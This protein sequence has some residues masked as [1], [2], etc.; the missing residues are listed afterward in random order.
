MKIS[1]S[2]VLLYNSLISVAGIA[3]NIQKMK[4][5]RHLEINDVKK[6]INY[7][8]SSLFNRYKNEIEPIAKVKQ[9]KDEFSFA[10]NN[11]KFIQWGATQ[12][13]DTIEPP[14]TDNI[15][16]Y[17]V[18]INAVVDPIIQFFEYRD[19]IKQF[20]PDF[21][22]FNLTP[23]EVS[24]RLEIIA[25]EK[26][27]RE[28][29]IVDQ[30]EK[31][32]NVVIA[33][34][35]IDEDDLDDF[36]VKDTAYVDSY[37]VTEINEPKTLMDICEDTQFCTKNRSTAEEHVAG[38][39]MFFIRGNKDYYLYAPHKDIISDS[40]NDESQPMSEES[41]KMI[42]WYLLNG[43]LQNKE[44]FN[45]STLS[46]LMQDGYM[47]ELLEKEENFAEE[48]HPQ[49]KSALLLYSQKLIPEHSTKI[50]NS[51]YWNIDPNSK[52]DLMIKIFNIFQQLQKNSEGQDALS[53]MYIQE[54]ERFNNKTVFNYYA[55]QIRLNLKDL[56]DN[57]IPELQQ[58]QLL[59]PGLG[60]DLNYISKKSFENQFNKFFNDYEINALYSG[61]VF[62]NTKAWQNALRQGLSPSEYLESF[63]IEEN[64]IDIDKYIFQQTT[65][66]FK[67]IEMI[68]E[69]LLDSHNLDSDEQRM[70]EYGM[71]F[72][73]NALDLLVRL[74]TV[75]KKRFYKFLGNKHVFLDRFFND[76]GQTLNDLIEDKVV[77]NVGSYMEY[78][79]EDET[80]IKGRVEKITAKKINNNNKFLDS[81][82]DQT[83]DFNL[84]N[85]DIF[86]I[87]KSITK[88][89]DFKNNYK[90]KADE[91]Y[92]LINR[93]IEI[94]P[95]DF[96]DKI[97]QKHKESTHRYVE[98]NEYTDEI[99]FATPYIIEAFTSE[100]FSGLE[101]GSKQLKMLSSWNNVANS[102]FSDR[103]YRLGDM[104][105]RNISGASLISGVFNK[106]LKQKFTGK[107]TNVV[108]DPA[109]EKTLLKLISLSKQ[110][111]ADLVESANTFG[112]AE[113][114]LGMLE[115]TGNMDM[116]NQAIQYKPKG[117]GWIEQE[118]KQFSFMEEVMDNYGI[119]NIPGLL[120]F[121][122]EKINEY[123]TTDFAQAYEEDYPD[124]NMDEYGEYY[125]ESYER[126]RDRE[127]RK[128][129]AKDNF[130][131][132]LRRLEQYMDKVDTLPPETY[133]NDIQ[134]VRELLFDEYKISELEDYD[135][136]LK[137]EYEYEEDD[138]RYS[139][140]IN[141]LFV[142]EGFLDGY[143]GGK[144]LDQDYFKKLINSGVWKDDYEDDYS[145]HL[146]GT[147]SYLTANNRLSKQEL[148]ETMGTLLNNKGVEWFVENIEYAKENIDTT[149]N[150]N[151]TKEIVEQNPNLE[152]AMG[153]NKTILKNKINELW[154]S[155]SHQ[156]KQQYV[157]NLVSN[158]KI[159]STLQTTIN[160]SEYNMFTFM[161]EFLSQ[162]EEGSLNKHLGNI[163]SP[164]EYGNYYSVFP[165][166]EQQQKQHQWDRYV[167]ETA[168][169]TRNV[170]DEI[171]RTIEDLD[172]TI[173]AYDNEV[174][175]SIV[176]NIYHKI[177]DL[178]FQRYPNKEILKAFEQSNW[179]DTTLL[180]NNIRRLKDS[181]NKF[182]SL[183]EN[184]N[185]QI[186]EDLDY[187]LS[188]LKSFDYN[189]KPTI[190]NYLKQ[191][192]R[193]A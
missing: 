130:T 103:N 66:N 76:N 139:F 155:K 147:L 68:L 3:E 58:Q 159:V 88:Y 145:A 7:V 157:R 176:E 106:Y 190:S 191:L 42:K 184:I 8:R 50:N 75:S 118:D 94:L 187:R 26:S 56:P 119:E 123:I 132:L 144:Y 167:Y 150:K 146:L 136:N 25:E 2:F 109:Q 41:Q 143:S 28:N 156:E 86:N 162:Y 79:D 104:Y 4:K 30:G 31:I 122:M 126:E 67:S 40:K 151:L 45:M 14:I 15:E 1:N 6:I 89:E 140:L 90:M 22:F 12:I 165:Q 65:S 78:I 34:F 102:L 114:L 128:S 193:V 49:A 17:I 153:D 154:N 93:L 149:I 35:F 179:I 10:S 134:N 60:E 69:T 84:S 158:E 61:K 62:M 74:S 85:N 39:S 110:A 92:Y 107:D 21:Y 137:D 48:L 113:T 163:Y 125:E 181:L 96:L 117:D 36:G 112:T 29:K 98:L 27:L 9:F 64:K 108:F 129:Q 170:K 185:P 95:D 47:S 71:K 77:N 168:E 19:F 135:L 55:D 13:L 152:D 171:N 138:L 161:S 175:Y 81:V 121:I 44:K 173:P 174:G 52:L 97:R 120:P 189:S 180:E 160:E 23:R 169:V 164:E 182:I 38:G 63:G 33:D 91:N 172:K 177:E 133:R 116:L 16:D 24:D 73:N 100:E 32:D 183:L 5:Y 83:I 115:K 141:P 54:Q 51:L 124:D 53:R 99:K 87:L 148:Y 70:H 72:R 11:A 43:F 127:S 142:E 192:Y 101:T 57:T 82:L 131:Q 37:S 178:M 105:E 18:E 186:A 80:D 59:F 188:Q 166:E 46:S 20:E 111:S